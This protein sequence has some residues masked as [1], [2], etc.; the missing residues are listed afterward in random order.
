MTIT[1]TNFS[2]ISLRQAILLIVSLFIAASAS[3]AVITPTHVVAFGDSLSDN[4]NF[5]AA[6]GST[7]PPAP[8]WNGRFSNGPVWVEQYAAGQGATL[9]GWAVGGAQTGTINNNGAMFDGM[10]TQ[11]GNYVAGLGGG[12]VTN[13]S[14]TLFTLWGGANNFL[15]MLPGDDPIAVLTGA[16]TDIGT[17]IGAL[18]GAGAQHFVVLG[19]PDLGL[20]PRKIAEG[21]AAQASASAISN[22]FNLQLANLLASPG[23]APLDIAQIDTYYLMQDVVANPGA[24]G[25]TNV[26]QPCF[27][28]TVPSLCANPDAYAFWDEIHPTAAMHGLVAAQVPVPG[29]VW[30]FVSA[31]GLLGWTR[32]KAA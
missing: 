20:T 16:I 19:L 30:L 14:T 15:A 9:D 28:S 7:I 29:A 31:L 12:G 23:L 27:D 2:F 25:L 10:T 17:M 26:T 3:A 22:V 24:Y 32:R 21:P 1:R 8:Y 11:V 6:T 4:G 5:Y 13:A 18:A